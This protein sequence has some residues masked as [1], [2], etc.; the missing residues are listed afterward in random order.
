MNSNEVCRYWANMVA[1]M[2]IDMI[3]PQHGR[4]FTGEAVG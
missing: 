1:D 4:A 3:V 2:D